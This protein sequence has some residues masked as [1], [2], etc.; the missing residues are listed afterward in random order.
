MARVVLA[1]SLLPFLVLAVRD[2]LLHFTV[3]RV[4][5]GENVLH[6]ILGVVLAGV[7]ARMFRFDR[8]HVVVG[9]LVFALFGAMDEFIF[10]RRIP[11]REHDTHAK[12]HFALFIFVAVYWC[13]MLVRR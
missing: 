9:T 5:L 10:H 6:L 12:E 8:P 2:Q 13:V 4:P 11:E 1:A 7:I 3:R